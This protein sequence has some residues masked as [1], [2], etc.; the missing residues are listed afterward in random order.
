[1]QLIARLLR[2]TGN[3]TRTSYVLCT[4]CVASPHESVMQSFHSD[5]SVLPDIRLSVNWFEVREL[6]NVSLGFAEFSGLMQCYL[7]RP[8]LSHL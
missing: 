5:H 3:D 1:M 6:E 7:F 2:G 4:K 8:H